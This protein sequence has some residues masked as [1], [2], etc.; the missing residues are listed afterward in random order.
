MTMLAAI[1]DTL[2]GETLVMFQLE[3]AQNLIYGQTGLYQGASF[4]AEEGVSQTELKTRIEAKL[5]KGFKATTGDEATEEASNSVSDQFG[6]FTIIL[7][8]SFDATELTNRDVL[9]E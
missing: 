4:S 2:A 7:S 5:P 3:H 8:S 1:R 9:A 6:V